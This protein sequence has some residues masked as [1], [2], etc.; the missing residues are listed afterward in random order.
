MGRNLHIFFHS[1]FG[2]YLLRAKH[3]TPYQALVN[4]TGRVL[5]LEGL[6]AQWRETETNT[7][8]DPLGAWAAPGSNQWVKERS[9]V[10]TFQVE[11]AVCVK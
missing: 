3:Y 8:S 7:I 1:T 2:E 6:L 10:L 9:E 5:T 4:Q 11:M